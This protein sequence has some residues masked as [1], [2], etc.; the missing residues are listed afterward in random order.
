MKECIYCKSTDLQKNIAVRGSSSIGDEGAINLFYYSEK[1]TWI[2]TN[3]G[4]ENLLAEVCKQCGSVR[5]YVEN[6]DRNW[7]E[8]NSPD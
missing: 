8:K 7:Y 3:F 2:G 6:A 1:K 5:I 4:W